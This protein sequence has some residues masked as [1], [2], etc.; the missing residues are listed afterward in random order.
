[1]GT[2]EQEVARLAGFRGLALVLLQVVNGLEPPAS[3]TT[4]VLLGVVRL[5]LRDTGLG[6]APVLDHA[7]AR[8]SASVSFSAPSQ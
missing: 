3:R 4:P 2:F 7:H 6:Q 1:M 5:A 8:T